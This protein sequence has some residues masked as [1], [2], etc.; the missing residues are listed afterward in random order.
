MPSESFTVTALP[1]SVADDAEFHVAVFVAPEIVPDFA[2][3]QLGEAQLFPDWAAVVAGDT[4]IELFDQ[5]SAIEATPLLDRIHPGE[6]PAVFPPD[7]PILNRR[8]PD[9][10]DRRWRS[11]RPAYLHDSAKLLHAV[12]MFADPTSPPLPTRHPLTGP[13]VSYLAQRDV[14]VRERYDESRVTELLDRAVGEFR[15]S[16]LTL[17]ILEHQLDGM[18]GLDRFALE[19][20][21]ARRF[22]ER[23]E[24][25]LPYQAR[26]TDGATM[27]K[28]APPVPDFHERVASV[29]DHS[30]LL[31]RLGLV[32]ELRVADPAR[33]LTSQWLS[34]RV[35]PR[36]DTKVG[37]LTRVRCAAVGDAHVTVPET[38]DWH[39]GALRLGDTDRFAV[40]DMDP[41]GTALKLD[42]YV[43]TLPRL[44]AIEQNGDPV[45]AAP[46]ALRTSGFTV[47]R[48]GR[49]QTAIERQ[50]RQTQ[51]QAQ[52]TAGRPP[53]LSTEDV[54]RGV[55]VEVWDDHDKTWSTLHARLIDA[56]AFGSG[57][58]FTAEKE[59]GFIQGTVVTEEVGV[60]DP[61][62]NVHESMFG[63]DGWSLAA[64]K[65]GRR[66]RHVNPPD[67]PIGPDGE[68]KSSRR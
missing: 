43:W 58:L 49:G 61:P 40:L 10:A 2:G 26:P 22:Y 17:P 63:W 67:A 64:P 30:V 42:R 1:H 11:F 29:G 66:V 50:T 6:W 35:I 4:R 25:A 55:R 65:P 45:H 39:E 24:S 38:P 9:L 14:P 41:D 19:L 31:R 23:P 28:L 37:R 68:P 44:M 48:S 3:Q 56:A 46:T 62:V 54:T 18:D 7:T 57:E 47:A 20:H 16:D 51:L 27:A 21:R 36:G 12:A 33:L 5:A 52:L 8:G 53:L 34:A 60:D 15:G 59:V 13:L 32:I